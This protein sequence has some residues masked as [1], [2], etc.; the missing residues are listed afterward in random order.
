MFQDRLVKEL[1]LRGISDREQAN[2]LLEKV[3]LPELNRRYAIKP[4]RLADMHQAA[5][6]GI[7]EILCVQEARVVGQDWCVRWQNRWL[8]IQPAEESRH[9]AGKQVV[10]KQLGSGKLLV[11]REDKP[12]AFKELAWRPKAAPIPKPL[13]QINNRRW[14]PGPDHPYNRQGR[15][16]KFSRGQGTLRPPPAAAFLGRR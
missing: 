9:L 13:P 6:A 11:L 5:P 12:L 10:V 7:R 1:R 8:Q 14:T 4:R 2:V 15:A 3:L 16:E